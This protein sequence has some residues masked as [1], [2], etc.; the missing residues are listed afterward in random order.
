MFHTTLP[1]HPHLQRF[2]P[3]IFCPFVEGWGR[4]SFWDQLSKNIA[5]FQFSLG[6]ENAGSIGQN[7]EFFI[8]VLE[9][10]LDFRCTR[11]AK[12][13]KKVRRGSRKM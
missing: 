7:V 2:S 11:L 9:L 12:E 8:G 10:E 13:E 5:H 3:C 6:W 1:G 4:G